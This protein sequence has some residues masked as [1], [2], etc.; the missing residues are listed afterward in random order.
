MGIVVDI[1]RV[2]CDTSTG[3]QNITGDLGGLDPKAAILIAT[4][5]SSDGTATD[6]AVLS[7]GFTDGTNE[8]VESNTSEHGVADSDSDRYINNDACVYFND[9]GGPGTDGEASFNAWLSNGIQINWSNAPAS[10][11]LLTVILLGGSDLSVEANNIAGLAQDA[12]DDVTEPGFEPD[13]LITVGNLG[14]FGDNS[15]SWIGCYGLV[16]N[17]R[18]SGITQRSM[19]VW[20]VN[21]QGDG[22]P[23]ARAT[24]T[25]GWMICNTSGA[26]LAALDFDTFD[27]SGFTATA[28]I[29]N[30]GDVPYLALRFGSGP[31]VE[32]WVGTHST[33]TSGGD[34]GE[35]GPGF[36]P[37][38]VF[39]LGSHMEAIDTAYA[40]NAL[41]G[42]IGMM[43]FDAG[44]EFA[45]SNSFEQGATTTDTQ[46]ISD[47]TAVELPDD[48]GGAGL[49]A[50]FV[51]FDANGWTLNYS[52][53][54]GNAKLFFALAIAEMPIEG[55]VTW[56]HDQGVVEANVEDFTGNW[57]GTGAISGGGDAE[58]LDL[59]T[60]ENMVSE[61]VNT[62]AYIVT[63]L[64][65]NYDGTGDDVDMDYRHGAT[66][67][68]CESAGWNNYTVPFVS[69]GYVQIRMTSTL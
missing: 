16:H 49:T 63:L 41:A 56:G 31:L 37:Q 9:P 62:G 12:A 27:S 22:L 35:T 18:A 52:A 2:A 44:A 29:G 48:D 64:Q 45:N 54:E 60:T 5:A 66:Q 38:F 43:A 33:P 61:V 20:D 36:T 7:F 4:R 11:Y 53:V 50:S 13:V 17:D 21:N 58:T 57:T 55:E 14:S 30:T 42:T 3:N 26:V 15:S 47:D 32:S 8:F 1:V 40:D 46:S 19:S 34:D 69:L 59:E 23:V 6:H 39:M 25:Y 51:S 65:N 67:G 10:A 28:R 24:N 68:D